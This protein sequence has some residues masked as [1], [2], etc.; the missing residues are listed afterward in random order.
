MLSKP[1]IKLCPLSICQRKVSATISN[2]VPQ[3]LNK[4]QSLLYA[5]PIDSKRFK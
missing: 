5:E 2:A 3:L 4:R 1:T